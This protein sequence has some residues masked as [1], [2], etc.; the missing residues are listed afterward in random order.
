MSGA[1]AVLGIVAGGAG[2]LSLSIQLGQS[3]F[4]LRRIYQTAKDAPQTV[5]RVVFELET[6]ALA[7]REI[8]K[9]RQLVNQDDESILRCVGHCQGSIADIQQLVDKLEAQISKQIK[10]RGKLYAVFKEPEIKDSFARLDKARSSLELAYMIYLGERQRRFQEAHTQTLAQHTAMLQTLQNQLDAPTSSTSRELVLIRQPSIKESNVKPETR[11]TNP[12]VLT[13]H[14][15]ES[16]MS[17]N[18]QWLNAREIQLGSHDRER[19]RSRTLFRARVYLPTFLSRVIWDVALT[20]SKCGWSVH[21]RSYNLIE[22]DSPIFDYCRDGRL[23]KI[24][25]AFAMGE[26]TPLDIFRDQFGDCTLLEEAAEKNR[27]DVCRYLLS[28][29]AYPDAPVILNWALCYFAVFNHDTS[30]QEEM[31][32][33]FLQE[34]DFPAD[35]NNP[36]KFDWWNLCRSTEILEIILPNRYPNIFVQS[37]EQRFELAFRLHQLTIPAFLKCT[38]LQLSDQRL[39]TVVNSRGASVLH[40]VAIRMTYEALLTPNDINMADIRELGISTLRHGADPCRLAQ[41]ELSYLTYLQLKTGSNTAIDTQ[42]NFT[43]LLMMLLVFPFPKLPMYRQQRLKHILLTLRTW[44]AMLNDAGIDLLKYGMQEQQIWRH[45]RTQCPLLV[46][47]NI[48]IV[49]LVFGPTPTDWSF[50]ICHRH[51]QYIYGLRQPP[52]S[53]PIEDSVP[54]LI[55]WRPNTEEALEGH[56]DLVD[57]KEIQSKEQDLRG[58]LFNKFALFSRLMDYTQDDNGN[59]ITIAD[60]GCSE[61][62]NSVKLIQEYLSRMPGVSSATLIFN[63][64]PF[65]DFSSLSSTIESN[66]TAL[67]QCGKVNIYPLLSPQSFYQRIVPHDT[68]DIGFCFTA[69]HWLQNVPNSPDLSLLAASAHAD[70]VTFLSARHKEIRLGGQLMLCIPIHGPFNVAFTVECMVDTVRTLAGTYGVDP[71]VIAKMP[72]HWRTMDEIMVSIAASDGAWELLHSSEIPMEHPAASLLKTISESDAE[73]FETARDK[74]ADIITGFA[75]AALAG[76]V[77]DDF[78][79]KIRSG[80]VNGIAEDDIALQVVRLRQELTFEYKK[81][82]LQTYTVLLGMLYHRTLRHLIAI[83]FHKLVTPVIYASRMTKGEN[84][85]IVVGG[86]FAGLAAAHESLK[87][88]AAVHMLERNPKAGGNSIKASSGI[89][90]AGTAFQ[91]RSGILDSIDHFYTDTVRSAGTR[92]EGD[93]NRQAL[94][95]MLTKQ[96]KDAITWLAD[97]IGIDLSVVAPLGGHSVARTHRGSGKMPPGASIVTTLLKDLLQ[98][99]RFQLSTSTEVIALEIEGDGVI[100]IRTKNENGIHTLRGPVVF[101]TGGFAGDAHGMM[102]KHCPKYAGIPSTNDN[103]PGS[104][105]LLSTLDTEFLDMDSVQIHPTGFVDPQDPLSAYKFLAAEMLRGE[106]G[107]LLMNGKRFVNEL[108]TREVWDVTLLLDPGACE[109]AASHLGFYQFKGLCQKTKVKNLEPDLIRAIDEYATVVATGHDEHGRENFGR[110]NLAAGEQNREQEVCVGKVT[111]VTHFTMGGAAINTDAQVLRRKN[112]NLTPIKGLWAAGEVTG[113]IHGDNRSALSSEDKAAYIESTLCLMNPDLAPSKTG[114]YGAKSRWDDLQVAHVAQ[115]QFIHGVGGFLPWHRY[116]MTVHENLLRKEC[117][118]KGA[119]PYWDE[120]VDQAAAPL[121]ESGIWS[122]DPKTGFGSAQLDAQGCVI[123]GAF[124]SLRHD[125]TIQLTRASTNTCLQRNLKQE[126]FDLVA[127]TI[128]SACQALPSFLSFNSCLGGPHASGHYAVGGTMDDA[129]LSPADPL[130]FMHH[131]N[132][133]RIWWEWQREDPARLT[134]IGGPNVAA[135]PM[136][137]NAQPKILGVDAFLPYF[138]DNGN[139]TTLNHVLWMGGA[140]E[141]ATIA[142]VMDVRSDLI[143]ADFE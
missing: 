57:V 136:L 72:V 44:I 81:Q 126:Q 47:R 6:I 30:S 140:A 134:E 95:R 50:M 110:W 63:D 102:A 53:Y 138:D 74:Y 21:L 123:D 88:G 104:H 99:Q 58:W 76:F 117:G 18:E 42:K 130:F 96:S 132:L 103:Q 9:Q 77:L 143:C 46:T 15:S 97:E 89:N 23:D 16:I 51:L 73:E 70:L 135:S 111:P 10:I 78:K 48:Q 79:A 93:A 66:R 129:S 85:V 54:R 137:V 114:L 41:H 2:L 124:T 39:S 120:Q 12:E 98:N 33:L 128:V 94:I 20:Q 113:G 43:P 83:P 45:L 34:R 142:E 25:E 19:R 108:E 127:Q 26:A 90:G 118:Y 52:C 133:D 87:A 38:G 115:V 5:E 13:H 22:E 55:A 64:T 49:D 122:A 67:S 24:Q 84:P 31:Y 40:Y 71:S 3:A 125:L 139:V 35:I 32:R 62:R 56:W 116:Y 106:G 86:G 82:L 61:G 131:T 11:V 4:K 17:N 37:V 101:A 80:N 14:G 29:T 91:Q 109:A 59:S 68:V 28:L 112:G 7:L 36:L 119:Y 105:A 65:N 1:E 121:N 141:N 60:Y 69:L 92:L 8:E 107:I 100:G 27:I 75:L